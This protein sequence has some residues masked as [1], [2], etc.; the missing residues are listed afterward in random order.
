MREFTPEQ[1]AIINGEAEGQ[2]A[3][4]MQL[5]HPEG[6]V[7]LCTLSGT[8]PWKDAENVPWTPAFG[9]VNFG[10][11]FTKEGL[12]GG[13]LEVTWSAADDDLMAAARDDAIAGCTFTR[14]VAFIGEDGKQVGGL[15]IDFQGICEV[16]QI[17]DE[18]GDISLSIESDLLR[19]SRTQVYRATPGSQERFFPGDSGFKFV[20]K[21]QD[22]DPYAKEGR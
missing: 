19:L 2:I 12:E 17:D 6:P 11:T 21:L 14:L 4:L 8:E 20:A 9:L 16:P 18:S 1:E 22:Y 10:P 3:L 7:R 13:A 5:D 15:L